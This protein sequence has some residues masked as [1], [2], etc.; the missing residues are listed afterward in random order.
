M[1][2]VDSDQDNQKLP[3]ISSQ[4]ELITFKS[5]DIT[6]ITGLILWLIEK[7]LLLQPALQLLPLQPPPHLQPQLPQPPPPQPLQPLHLLQPPQQ[8]FHFALAANVALIRLQTATMLA[9]NGKIVFNL[10][11]QQADV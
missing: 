10:P 9:M 2:S 3:I 1:I 4:Q 5:L 8:L 6:D 7:R 11:A